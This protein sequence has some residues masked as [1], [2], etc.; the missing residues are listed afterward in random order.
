MQ[1]V[2]V[3]LAP[4]GLKEHLKDLTFWVAF[5]TLLAVLY[6]AC[7]TRR[8]LISDTRPVVA[9]RR[10]YKILPGERGERWC[11]LRYGPK[12]R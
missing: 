5:I 6:Y 9:I 3:K 4:R 8:I 11:C 2:E 12:L 10:V 1:E 7:L